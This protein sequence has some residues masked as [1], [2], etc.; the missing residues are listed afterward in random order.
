MTIQPDYKQMNR[1]ELR[2]YMLAHRDDEQAFHAYMD[3]VQQESIKTPISDE[4][5]ADP[6]KFSTFLEQRKQRKQQNAK[7]Q[8]MTSL[9]T[10]F[11]ALV[12]QL[13]QG[14]IDRLPEEEQT[15]LV[16]IQLQHKVEKDPTF[17]WQLLSAIKSRDIEKVKVL[18]NDLVVSIPLETLKGWL[19]ADP[20]E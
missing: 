14:L 5:L 9:A 2:E 4:V 15:L 13:D 12:T 20:K 7:Q 1:A 19:E 17:K 6:Q 16:K 3:K 11:Q 8:G 10:K 18:T